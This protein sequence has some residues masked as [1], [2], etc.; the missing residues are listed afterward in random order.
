VPEDARPALAELSDQL[1]A[2]V[3]VGQRRVAA[4]A[5]GELPLVLAAVLEELNCEKILTSF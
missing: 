1:E 3:L 4:V 2:A 5:A